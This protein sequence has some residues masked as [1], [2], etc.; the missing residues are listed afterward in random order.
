MST[1]LHL[2][3][4]RDAS[5]IRKNGLKIGK[6]R[7]GIYCMPVL[8]NFYVSHQW[9]RELKRNGARTYVGVYFKI[10]SKEMVYAG[11]YNHEHRHITLGEAIKEIM[12][13]EDPL[14]YELIIPRKIEAK[15]IDKIK[16]L[17]QKL[18]W[19]YFPNSHAKKPE[20]ACPFCIP[21]G[22]IK[23]K[24]LRDKIN[25]PA[26]TLTYDELITQ[27]KTAKENDGIDEILL[28]LPKLR[29]Q[30]DPNDLLFLLDKGSNSINQSLALALGLYKHPNTKGILL[31]LLL[32]EDELTKEFATDSL[33]KLYRPD[34]EKTLLDMNDPIINKTIDEWNN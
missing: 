2:A 6:D 11:R 13:L 31:K 18:G 32:T 30:A 5:S 22:S 12:D 15:A 17:P 3:D 8:P 4:E 19:R 33:L 28:Q 24:I 14:G 16:M 9:L 27:L 1:L 10:D 21:S 25:P 23:G 34:I 26:K 7:Q 29:K 20:C